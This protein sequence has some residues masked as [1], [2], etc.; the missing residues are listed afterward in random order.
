[1][2]Q[3]V[4]LITGSGDFVVTGQIPLFNTYPGV[5]IWGARIFSFD[6]ETERDSAPPLLTYREIFTTSLVQYDQGLTDPLGKLER[7]SK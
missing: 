3:A 1:M 5:L 6:G 7:V 4:R 2:F